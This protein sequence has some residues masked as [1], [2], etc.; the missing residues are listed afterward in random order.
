MEEEGRGGGG[1]RGGKQPSRK[2]STLLGVLEGELGGWAFGRIYGNCLFLLLE[3]LPEAS[4][5]QN[6]PEA[7]MRL[8]FYQLE[9]TSA[10]GGCWAPSQPALDSGGGG[11]N[12]QPHPAREE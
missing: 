2:R 3:C 7:I 6:Q 11:Q 1:G 8:K 9:A 10:E 5:L 4:R 12:V